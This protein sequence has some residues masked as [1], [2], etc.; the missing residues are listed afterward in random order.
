MT[1]TVVSQPNRLSFI[2]KFGMRIEAI[3]PCI[4][5]ISRENM[6]PNDRIGDLICGSANTKISY[7]H[8]YIYVCMQTNMGVTLN[9]SNTNVAI[10][11]DQLEAIRVKLIC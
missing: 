11:N 10:I 4:I 7:D 6:N 5:A 8:K 3:D 1:T 9:L 2:P